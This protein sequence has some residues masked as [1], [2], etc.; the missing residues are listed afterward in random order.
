MKDTWGKIGLLLIILLLTA[1]LLVMLL[2][3]AP[4]REARAAQLE[5]IGP[6]AAFRGNGIGIACSTDGRY[7]YAAGSRM[8]YRSTN[9]GEKG[10]WEPVLVE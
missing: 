8:I 5:K 7:V 2:Y 9:F 1:N 4:A 6:T 3:K 10:S